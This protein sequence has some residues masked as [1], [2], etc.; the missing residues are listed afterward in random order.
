MNKKGMLKFISLESNLIL[1][2]QANERRIGSKVHTTWPL[3]Y[4]V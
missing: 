4:D 2:C 1:N 3:V